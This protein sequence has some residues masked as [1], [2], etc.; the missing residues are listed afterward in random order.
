MAPTTADKKARLR[1]RIPSHSRTQSC[2]LLAAG[3]AAILGAPAHGETQFEGQIAVTGHYTD[4]FS[5]A[6]AAA[7]RDSEVI[8]EVLPH[9]DLQHES[10]RLQAAA[11]YELRN[12]FY[13]GDS[14]LNQTYHQ[15]NLGA[16][17]DAIPQWFSLRTDGAYAQRVV[18][19]ER[20]IDFNDLFATGNLTDET[21]ANA[22]PVFEHDFRGTTLEAA[23]TLG[24]VHYA[25]PFDPTS[26]LDNSRR[27]AYRVELR[28]TDA[29]P[30][31]QVSWNLGYHSERITYDHTLPYQYDEAIAGL[32]VPVTRH[33]ILLAE[34]GAESDL[35]KDISDGGLDS[36]FWRAGFRMQTEADTRLEFKIG[37]RFFG[38]T[39]SGLFSRKARLLRFEVSY[40]EEPQTETERLTTR[41][42]PVIPV[43][44]PLPPSG[45]QPVRPTAEPYVLKFLDSSLSLEGRVTTVTLGVYSF[46]QNYI[47]VSRGE[48]D[49]GARLSIDRRFGPRTT[50]TLTVTHTGTFFAENPDAENKDDTGSVALMRQLSRTIELTVRALYL[51]RTGPASGDYHAMVYTVGFVKTF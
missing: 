7:A 29:Q 6:S 32:G 40:I 3:A 45:A 4:N 19:P 46:K 42:R 31:Q 36:G 17:W 25:G 15:A 39:Y 1:D 10:Q 14:A 13:M 38:R 41:R 23:Y 51:T 30:D 16:T 11:T 24:M 33:F 34:G 44:T 2:A 43:E 27:H 47:R 8:L 18:R 48:R 50:G 22:T 21:S 9:F 49:R 12:F 35:A 26:D 5:L 37:H 20:A 28:P